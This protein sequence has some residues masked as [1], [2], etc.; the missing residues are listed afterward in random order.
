M[1]PFV[2]YMLA[3]RNLLLLSVVK[4]LFNHIWDVLKDDARSQ[5]DLSF[6]Y[7]YGIILRHLLEVRHYQFHMTK[8]VYCS[9][10]PFDIALHNAFIFLKFLLTVLML[11]W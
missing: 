3:G 1:I 7:E 4:V 10:S 5:D 11:N 2:D 6:Q 8:R 9:E